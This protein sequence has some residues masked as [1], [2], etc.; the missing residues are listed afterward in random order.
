MKNIVTRRAAAAVGAAG[1]AVMGVGSL[2]TGA[3]AAAPVPN[4]SITK[5]LVDG[6]SV[7]IQ[8]FDQNANIQRPLIAFPMNR[9][10]WVS[11]KV[12]VTL[13]GEAEEA[14]ISAGYIVGCQVNIDIGGGAGTDDYPLGI[15]SNTTPDGNGGASTTVTPNAGAGGSISLGPGG[16]GYVPIIQETNDDDDA[17]ESYTFSGTGGGVAY[18]Q[19]R[20]W[21][22]DCAGY[23]EAKAKVTVT[24]ETDAVKGVVTLYGQPFSLG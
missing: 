16:A 17:V 4:S 1:V 19:E 9:E 13:G 10:V 23:A 14:E 15:G 8:L 3:A 22:N 24:V 21:V 5:T 20:F 12:R 11:G 7:N 6:T 2:G 18:S